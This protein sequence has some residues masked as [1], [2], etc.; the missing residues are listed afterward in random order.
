MWKSPKRAALLT[1]LFGLG[2]G[3]LLTIL[4]KQDTLLPMGIGF[5]S[6]MVLGILVFARWH[7]NRSKS[8]F[9]SCF[10]VLYLAFML[11]ALL[12]LHREASFFLGGHGLA[13]W[14]GTQVWERYLQEPLS[15]N[16][17]DP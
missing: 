1:T 4:G 16:D 9:F 7:K 8:F 13:F 11:A 2:A 5:P 3:I 6:G 12:R 14:I 17:L 15:W 10:L